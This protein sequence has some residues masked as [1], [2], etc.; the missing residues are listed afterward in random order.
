MA[1]RT[2]A[3]VALPSVLRPFGLPGRLYIIASNAIIF[4]MPKLSKTSIAVKQSQAQRAFALMLSGIDKE[5]ALKQVGISDIVFDKWIVSDEEAMKAMATAAADTQRQTLAATIIARAAL[6]KRMMDMAVS[7]PMPIQQMVLLDKHLAT[8]QG[9]LSAELGTRAQTAAEKFL[10][11]LSG[12][13]TVVAESVF[14]AKTVRTET[15]IEITSMPQPELPEPSVV[16][17]G[18]FRES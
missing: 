8:V 14:R 17:E 13:K 3:L 12:P 15:E 5:E 6:A 11:N 18:E 4:A 9:E 16:I 1:T 2:L 7:V 10:D